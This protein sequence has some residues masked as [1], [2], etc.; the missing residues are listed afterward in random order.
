VRSIAGD[1]TSRAETRKLDVNARDSCKRTALHWATE[2][3]H[4][5]AVR[6][7]L[8]TEQVDVYSQDRAG[9]TPRDLAE[10]VRAGT[11]ALLKVG[12]SLRKTA[13]DP[14]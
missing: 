12:T 7:L 2:F 11:L 14:R 4:E 5:E 13:L 1:A 9:D 10:F 6:Q 8:D 3:G